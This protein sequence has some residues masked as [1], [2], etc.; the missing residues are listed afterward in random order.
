MQKSG[1]MCDVPIGSQIIA[2][3]NSCN[4]PKMAANIFQDGQ[5]MPSIGSELY[6]R[7]WNN[8]LSNLVLSL[9]L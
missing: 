2:P 1:I 4:E 3:K 5:N 7:G 8:L 6:V 9:F